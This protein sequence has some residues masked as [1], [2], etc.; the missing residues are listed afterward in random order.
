MSQETV[1]KSW[2]MFANRVA[3]KLADFHEH[4]R[5]C[6]AYRSDAEIVRVRV[7]LDENGELYGWH[8]YASDD[9][10]MIYAQRAATEMCFAYGSRVEEERGRGKLVRLSAVVIEEAP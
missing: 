5:T 9:V 4:P 1:A 2:V 10:S 6:K 8:E 3:G 7:T